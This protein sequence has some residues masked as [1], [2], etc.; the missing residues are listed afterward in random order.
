MDFPEQEQNR[1]RQYLL[2]DLDEEQC[3][4]LEEQFFISPDFKTQVLI[5]EDEIAEDYLAGTLSAK[6]EE[7]FRQRLLITREQTQRFNVIKSLGDYA[8]S[9]PPV[10]ISSA[11][12]EVV[13]VQRPFGFK[14]WAFLFKRPVPILLAAVV[15]LAVFWFVFQSLKH[16]SNSDDLIRRQEL[17]R[18]V[19]R[20]NSPDNQSLPPDL[21][22]SEAQTLS[23][24]LKPDLLRD[25]SEQAK[26]EIS[27]NIKILQLKL[28][29]LTA[30][31][32]NYRVE[33]RNSNGVELLRHDGLTLQ[34]S[35]GSQTIIFNLPSSALAPNDYLLRLSGRNETNHY[36]EVA[37]YFFRV[38]PNNPRR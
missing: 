21:A 26:V 32:D 38:A 19:S 7:A 28:K 36:E 25:S 17:E 27:S 22:A 15:L 11:T 4:Q 29:L 24:T 3:Q 9:Q 2:G 8:A 23:L 35:D 37:E 1:I 5:A 16:N 30:Q 31:Y 6:E 14:L 13:E 12:E 18:Q 20:L 10:S 34:T 33:L